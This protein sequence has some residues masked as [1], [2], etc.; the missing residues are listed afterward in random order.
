MKRSK[1]PS[2]VL[3]LP[4]VVTPGQ[5]RVLLARFEA[6]RRLYNAVLGEALRRRKLMRESRAWQKARTLK[7]KKERAADFRKC[8]KEHGFTS[9]SLSAFGTECKNAAG[10]RDRLGAHET[11]KIAER[12]FSAVEQYGYG[13]RGKPRFKGKRRPLHSI[14]SKSNGAGIRW[15]P[16]TASVEWNG[17]FLQSLAVPDGADPWREE[18]L[19][20][21]TKF[22]R[23]LWRVLNGKRRWYVQL[24]QEGFPPTKHA[25]GEGIVGLDLG[26]STVA[27]VG[28]TVADLAA[29]CPTIRQPWKEVRRLQRKLDRS[30][31]ATNPDCFNP[32]GTWKKGARQ[33]VFSGRYRKT[34]KQLAEAERR[35]AAERKRSHGELANAVLSH[36]AIVQTETLSYKA[37]QKRFGRSVKVKAPG[38][39]IQ[40][41]RRKAE[42]AGGEVLNLNTRTLK[43]SQYDHATE[44]FA[45]KPLSQR[46]HVLG[47]G[48][49]IVQRDIYSA[50]LARC[51]IDNRHH[52]PHIASMWAAAEP[53]LRQAGWC[54]IQPASGE[55]KAFPTVKPSERVA[56]RR[57]LAVGHSPDAVAE[58]REPGNP[59]GFALGT[60]CL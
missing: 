38:M 58:T 31:R 51:V 28:E 36:G 15:K 22:C 5:E 17:L 32:N 45:K 48:T 56:C 49:R 50:F 27:V 57:E 26:P 60:P 34:A 13:V 3:E 10:F 59:D 19:C 46:W 33:T 4:L 30:R 14:E 6:A 7:D 24:L 25:V 16:G 23:L 52:P 9:E 12:A 20:R 54:R 1:T 44:T 21:S 29:F 43:L 37:F 55:A 39:F 47:D 18:A 2:F 8:G 40:Q 53:L 42:S 41:L 35:L 11:Q